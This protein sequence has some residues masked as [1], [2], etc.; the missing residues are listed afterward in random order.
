MDV[1]AAAAV[2]SRTVVSGL[3]ALQGLEFIHS[4]RQIHR[5]IKPSNL[6]INHNGDVKISDF[7]LIKEMDSTSQMA[8]TF[9]GTLTYMSPERIAGEVCVT[10]S[11]CVCV[12]LYVCVLVRVWVCAVCV[13]CARYHASSPSSHCASL[14]KC[15]VF[16]DPIGHCH[17]YPCVDWCVPTRV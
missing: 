1:F 7:G 10:V 8:Q 11:L 2:S 14:S 6:L 9:V 15:F 17:P 4:K 3:G 12:C 13:A 5:D 16:A